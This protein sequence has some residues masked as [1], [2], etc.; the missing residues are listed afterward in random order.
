M[1]FRSVL[2]DDRLDDPAAFAN[3]R[4]AVDP[5]ISG[6]GSRIVFVSPLN[7]T[8][9]TVSTRLKIYLIDR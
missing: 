8:D 1:L 7:Y 9:A 4:L 6:D 5:E 3:T 2:T